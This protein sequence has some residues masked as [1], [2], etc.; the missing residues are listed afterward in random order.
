MPNKVP[1]DKPSKQSRPSSS[2]QIKETKSNFYTES[3]RSTAPK[4]KSKDKKT[5]TPR[6]DS[7]KS[8]LKDTSNILK[9]EDSIKSNNI[10]IMNNTIDNKVENELIDFMQEKKVNFNLNSKSENMINNYKNTEKPNFNEIKITP[11]INSINKLI[12][13][14][15]DVLNEQ[16]NLIYN[17]NEINKKKAFYMQLL[18]IMLLRS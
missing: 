7:K 15:Q 1:L 2:K 8:S 12:N 13:S 4:G 9:I 6:K 16:K 17:L 14:S 3:N 11:N 5:I 18:K 10:N